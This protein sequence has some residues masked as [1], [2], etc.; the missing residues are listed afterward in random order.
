MPDSFSVA[1]LL[2][3]IPGSG[4]ISRALDALSATLGSF[5]LLVRSGEDWLAFRDRLL[6]AYRGAREGCP[7]AELG[8]TIL[9][10][11]NKTRIRPISKYS[12]S[13]SVSS[14]PTKLR[15]FN[16][17]RSASSGSSSK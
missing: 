5:E 13:I 10:A 7:T 2:S 14:M 1:R 3:G 9:S 16:F 11:R 12:F 15:P 8:F 6:G 17:L 4:T